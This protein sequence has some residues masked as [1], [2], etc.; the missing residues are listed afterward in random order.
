MDSGLPKARFKMPS[1]TKT[2]H[3]LHERFLATTSHGHFPGSGNWIRTSDLV[4]TLIPYFRTSVDYLITLL[5]QGRGKAL[6]IRQWQT[7][8]P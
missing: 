4:V 5:L 1:K 6:P 7:V 3:D 2:V 8:L